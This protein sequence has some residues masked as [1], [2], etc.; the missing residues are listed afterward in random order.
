MFSR[1]HPFLF[2]ILSLASLFTF[3]CLI[4]IG[5][6][7]VGSRLLDPKL[8]SSGIASRGN[9]GIVEIEGIIT[10]SKEWIQQI[11][12]FRENDDIKAIVIRIN[13][14][15]GGIGPS[16]ELYRE[17][18]KT[19]SEKDVLSSMGSVAASGGYYIASACD[20]IVANKGTITGSIGVI[21]EYT[22][23]EEAI[24]KIGLSPVIIK[25]GEFKDIG[26]PFRAI[27]DSER[28]FLQT[29]VDELHQQF[30]Q[31]VAQ[32]RGLPVENVAQYADGRILT[33]QTAFNLHFVDRIGNLDDAVQWAGEMAGITD[34]LIPVYPEEDRMDFLKNFVHS[35]LKDLNISSAISDNFRFVIN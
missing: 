13:T 20:K 28:E 14:P 10:S 12:N 24:R 30:V 22:N 26:S 23:I 7:M 21:M 9:I 25:S 11:K 5:V 17:I 19:R 2:F 6:I 16:Q 3:L 18:V 8:I 34:E 15:G 31:D 32:G 33:G 1:R 29:V 35:L 27:K 4:F